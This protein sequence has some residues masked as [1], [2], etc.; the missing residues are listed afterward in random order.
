MKSRFL[1]PCVAAIFLLALA[2]FFDFELSPGMS[3]DATDW[4][5]YVMHARN[6][7]TG[8]PYAQTGYVFQPEVGAEI[9]ATAYPAGFPLML[10]PFYAVEGL[11]IKVFK[12]LNAGFLVLSLWAAYLFARRTLSALG[13]LVL[14]VALGFS[15]LFMAHFN[16]IGSDAPYELVS[17]LVLLLLLRIYDQRLNETSPWKWGLWAGMSIVAA[18]L[19]RP[20][21]LA[22]LV[23]VAFL[24][25]LQKRR[26]T[27]FLTATMAAFVPLMLLNN[28]LFHSDG[29]YA[30]QFTFSILSIARHALEYVS[31]FSYVF[32]NPLSNLFRYILWAATLVPVVFGI[33]R[34]VRA[35]LSVTELY[36]LILLGV[37]S[38]YWTANARYLLPLMPIYLVYMFEGFQVMEERFPQRWRL[39]LK[40]L[41]AALLLLAPAAN[42]FRVRPDSK[43]TLVTAPR[44]E[45]LCAAVRRQTTPN[46]LVIFWNP[47]VF[48]F[49]T[50]R[51]SSGWP[52]VGMAE[53]IQYLRRVH[54]N[55][56]VADK[57]RPDDRR[58]LLPVL[59]GSLKGATIYEN[60]EFRLV[61]VLE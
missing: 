4:A 3:S 47:R 49:S 9:G 1:V 43:D 46:A 61:Q 31:L 42:A 22:F 16:S 13:S 28:L 32:A 60:D 48:A 15:W 6:I 8:H 29:G 14:I 52:A 33:V 39:P 23:A 19:I 40:A 59:D 30:D 27:A 58:F 11:N 35:G 56:I 37:E 57:S 54:P 24:E 34:R 18:Y 53:E 12:L 21:G 17:L 2:F 10:A 41:A 5:M 44:Y 26:I 25:I 51:F 38:V 50:G 55:Y 45:E 20:F 36:V 7:V